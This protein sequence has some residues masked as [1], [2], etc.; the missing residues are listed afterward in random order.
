MPASR[1]SRTELRRAPVPIRS[2]HWPIPPGAKAGKRR[3][4]G[5]GPKQLV[6]GRF[7]TAV[8]YGGTDGLNPVPSSGESGELSHCA[9]G[10]SLYDPRG[11]RAIVEEE[12]AI[13]QYIPIG[14]AA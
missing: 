10:L 3:A 4:I 9:A 13:L 5:P 11:R 6:V 8:P 1:P 2:R 14:H 12:T 7:K